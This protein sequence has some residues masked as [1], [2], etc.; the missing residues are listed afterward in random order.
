MK[1]FPPPNLLFPEH[2][3]IQ[4]SGN[5][6]LFGIHPV[7]IEHIFHV[8]NSIHFPWILSFL[9]FQPL[10]HCGSVRFF[11]TFCELCFYAADLTRNSEHAFACLPWLLAVTWQI[12]FIQ[13]AATI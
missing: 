12:Q 11:F 3:K 6:Y 4:F 2:G 1:C 8:S 9:G 7:L 5:V 13:T 10:L